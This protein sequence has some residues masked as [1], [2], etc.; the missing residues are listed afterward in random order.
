[1]F[2]KHTFEEDGTFWI[3]FEDF[4]QNFNFIHFCQKSSMCAI[5]YKSCDDKEPHVFELVLAV[6]S[7]ISL[8]A[9][10]NYWRFKYL[11]IEF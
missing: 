10:K 3:R 9:I 11:I 4:I 1:M 5:N 2:G 6:K 8:Q 7:Q